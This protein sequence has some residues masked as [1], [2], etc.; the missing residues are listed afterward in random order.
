MTRSGRALRQTAINNDIFILQKHYNNKVPNDLKSERK[1]F[2]RIIDNFNRQ[3]A[4]CN[5]EPIRK[6]TIDPTKRLL[7]A[8]GVE[9]PN[10]RH[11]VPTSE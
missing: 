4:P 7:E 10:F 1:K 2:Q 3:F 9:F 5:R 11:F 8:Q 6:K